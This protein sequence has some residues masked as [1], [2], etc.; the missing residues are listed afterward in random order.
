MTAEEIKKKD[1]EER[2]RNKRRLDLKKKWEKARG[3][4]VRKKERDRERNNFRQP[5]MRLTK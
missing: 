5:Y 4:K 2:K 1:L 3:K